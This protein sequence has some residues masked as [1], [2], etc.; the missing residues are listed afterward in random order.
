[1]TPLLVPDLLTE[2]NSWTW[3]SGLHDS[4]HQGIY[5][6]WFPLFSMCGCTVPVMLFCRGVHYPDL[7]VR[8]GKWRGGKEPHAI[9]DEQGD[10]LH[11]RCGH[12]AGISRPEHAFAE[13][14]QHFCVMV[15]SRLVLFPKLPFDQPIL[16][17]CE[18]PWGPPLFFFAFRCTGKILR[19][20][21]KRRE[22]VLRG[23]S[24]TLDALASKT[25]KLLPEVMM[26][27]CSSICGL[28][29]ERHM[30]NRYSPPLFL[31]TWADV[32]Q[33]PSINNARANIY[34]RFRTFP[35]LDKHLWATSTATDFGENRSWQLCHFE[36]K[37]CMNNVTRLNTTLFPSL[38][39]LYIYI[40]RTETFPPWAAA[41]F[42]GAVRPW[43][44]D[45]SALRRWEFC[46]YVS[47]GTWGLEFLDVNCFRVSACYCFL[48]CHTVFLSSFISLCVARSIQPTKRKTFHRNK[49][50]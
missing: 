9:G 32:R 38:T 28:L 30:V 31:S 35:R 8:A 12:A 5:F 17:S 40:N 21:P 14:Y 24:V 19:S 44:R 13:L 1:M 6:F 36:W 26:T 2:H 10:H 41:I 11:R 33:K 45:H 37:S 18:F 34:S 29:H 50:R 3:S 22:T 27:R 16:T 23:A 7:N 49:W 46:K 43:A 15:C 47:R 39:L 48:P 20:E 42:C 4:S 25:A